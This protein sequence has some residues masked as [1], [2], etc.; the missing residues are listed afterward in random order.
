MGGDL[1]SRKSTSDYM[2]FFEA[3]SW[4]CN[5]KNCVAL[6]TIETDVSTRIKKERKKGDHVLQPAR[7]AIA[8]AGCHLRGAPVGCHSWGAILT[9]CSRVVL[10]TRCLPNVGD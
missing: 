9:M 2:I 6:F 7:C 4:H 3:L 1:N 5:L 10:S 8:P